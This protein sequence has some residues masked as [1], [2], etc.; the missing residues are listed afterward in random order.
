VEARAEISKKNTAL[1][2]AL[3]TA[4]ATIAQQ[5][6]AAT[7]MEATAARKAKELA[8]AAQAEISAANEVLQMLR[9][10]LDR[11][12]M[13]MAPTARAP[14]NTVPGPVHTTEKASVARYR[15]QGQAVHSGRSSNWASASS[16]EAQAARG[17]PVPCL[18]LWLVFRT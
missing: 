17:S 16:Q 18:V 6:K 9:S 11:R 14:V 10:R 12:G 2:T 4:Q 8:A 1:A 7:A 13:T 15:R 5:K 3:A